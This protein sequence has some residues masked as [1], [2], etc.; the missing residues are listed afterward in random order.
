MGPPLLSFEQTSY[1]TGYHRLLNYLVKPARLE[2]S[3]KVVLG[4]QIRG[5]WRALGSNDASGTWCANTH[6]QCFAPT[7][8]G[9]YFYLSTDAYFLQAAM[10]KRKIVDS[11]S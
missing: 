5:K 11:T 3:K 4:Y 2:E 8:T 1:L 9:R 7:K 10:Q 6:P